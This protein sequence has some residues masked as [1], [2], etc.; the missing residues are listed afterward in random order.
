MLL[1]AEVI[2]VELYTPRRLIVRLRTDDGNVVRYDGS[3]RELLF[4]APVDQPPKEPP[5]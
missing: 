1:P 2:E 4:F 3:P 5:P